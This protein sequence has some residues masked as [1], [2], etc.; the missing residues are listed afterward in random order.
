MVVLLLPWPLHPD[1][2]VLWRTTICLCI[3]MLILVLII[4]W[5][6]LSIL[7]LMVQLSLDG[8]LPYLPAAHHLVAGENAYGDYTGSCS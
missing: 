1:L 8:H 2:L 4:I 5:Q 6:L 3:I 7:I